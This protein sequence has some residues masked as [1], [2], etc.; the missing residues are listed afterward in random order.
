MA[1]LN[2]AKISL[3]V[4]TQLDSKG[5]LKSINILRNG[6]NAYKEK[7]SDL[8]VCTIKA[9]YY[10][11][12]LKVTFINGDAAT[13]NQG[14]E[15]KLLVTNNDESKKIKQDDHFIL[16]NVKFKII[17]LGDVQGIVF[18]MSLERM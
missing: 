15:D 12:N 18:D 9:Y 14:N 10:K 17:D 16:D 7:V 4:Y 6:E 3:K 5:L 11:N 1:G 13:V 2:R 8:Y